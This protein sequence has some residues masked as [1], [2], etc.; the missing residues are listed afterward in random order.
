MF[1][2]RRFDFETGLYYYRARYYNPYIGRFLQTD[3]VGYDDGL[4]WYAYCG[5]NPIVYV[6]P[7]GTK[8]DEPGLITYRLGGNEYLNYLEV[9][10]F[11]EFKAWLEGLKAEGKQI[12][13]FEFVGHGCGN[14]L[15][16][17]SDVLG[18]GDTWTPKDPNEEI[19]KW[20]GIGEISSLIQSVFH[21][22][23]TIELEACYTLED[24]YSIGYAFHAILPKA[25]IWGYTG[26]CQKYPFIWETHPAWLLD[27]DSEWKVIPLN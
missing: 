1:T 26:E 5:N 22:E 19:D 8:L 15:I 10:S 3:P 27:P 20:Y 25:I 23:C 11:A 9:N 4:N 2:G 18:T 24:K 13:F 12:G 21:P 16:M 7:F 14:G 6:D 17:G